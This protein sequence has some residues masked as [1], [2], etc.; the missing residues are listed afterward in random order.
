[1]SSPSYP[2]RSELLTVAALTAVTAVWGSSFV[3]I[4]GLVDRIPPL[5][6][7]GLR[8]L[9]AGLLAALIWRRAMFEA[10]KLTW[11]RGVVLGAVWASAQIAQTYGL[12]YTSASISGFISGLYVV[13]TPVLMVVLM[14]VRISPMSW[15]AFAIATFGIGVLTINFDQGVPTL[16]FGWGEFLTLLSSVLYAL[17]I[18]LLGRWSQPDIQGQ[19][20]VIQIVTLGAILTC[21]ALPGGVVLPVNVSEWAQVLYMAVF[22]S[23]FALGVQTWAQA[24][25][26][27]T[28]TAIILTGEPVW[29]AFFAVTVGGEALTAG[30]LTG[31][32]LVVAAML[33]TELLPLLS[34]QRTAQGKEPL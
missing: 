28:K 8:F 21:A 26:S 4:H 31:G 25:I 19:L 7:L 13:M 24:R 30:M 9:L 23:I 29:G 34:A 2:W 11:N 27:P 12:A 10:T 14:R 6:F 15:L 3:V 1:M 33:M 20:T 5:D 32:T 17:H 18:V 16:S 22:G